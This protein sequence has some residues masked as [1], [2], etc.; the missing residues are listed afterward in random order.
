MGPSHT[1]AEPAVGAAT[2]AAI[3]SN[4]DRAAL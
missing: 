3:S 1:C 2:I 4:S